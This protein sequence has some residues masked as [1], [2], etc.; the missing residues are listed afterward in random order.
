MKNFAVVSLLSLSIFGC[1]NTAPSEQK[2]ASNQN[3]STEPVCCLS[4]ADFPWIVLDKVDSFKFEIDKSAPVWGFET[5][6]SYFTAFEFS[7]QSGTVRVA[8]KSNMNDKTVFSPSI[9][10]LD[11]NYLVT[12]TLTAEDFK[13]RFSDAMAKNRYEKTF[14]VDSVK[15]P[16]MVVF[17][18][19]QVIGQE[20]TIPHP[21]KVRAIESGEPM[22]IVTDPKYRHVHTGE[23][24]LEIETL[25]LSGYKQKKATPRSEPMKKVVSDV[26]PLKETQNY[27]HSAIKKAVE[28]NDI[29]KALSL[30]DE[31]K[32]LNVEG[33]Q[34]VF[35]NAVNAK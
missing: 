29:P 31:A 20:V 28:A 7:E 27:Y 21:A 26:R 19:S 16:Y 33:A 9:A 34:E 30:L 1:A 4:E 14:E 12:K 3:L 35:V 22:P 15:T 10:L 6:N 18:D 8:L 32:A 17:T 11:E 2:L 23:L 25:S 24:E 13:I 5:G